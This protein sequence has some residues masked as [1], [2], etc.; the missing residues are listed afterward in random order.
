MLSNCVIRKQKKR[1]I[2]ETTL[3]FNQIIDADSQNLIL[4]KR[5]FK[6]VFQIY[7]QIGYILDVINAQLKLVKRVNILFFSFGTTVVG[8]AADV[9]NLHCVFIVSMPLFHRVPCNVTVIKQANVPTTIELERNT[10]DRSRTHLFGV[11]L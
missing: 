2:F 10:A 11:A 9:W 1:E 8:Q 3:S 4:R 5:P 6:N 7:D